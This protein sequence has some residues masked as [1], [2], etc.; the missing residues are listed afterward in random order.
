MLRHDYSNTIVMG[1]PIV[2]NKRDFILYSG[3]RW[4]R[5]NFHRFCCSIH[6]LATAVVD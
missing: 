4:V 6:F 3:H 5:D 2:S 1:K